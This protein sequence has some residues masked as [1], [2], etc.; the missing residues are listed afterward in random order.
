M[1][2]AFRAGKYLFKLTLSILPGNSEKYVFLMFSAR[3]KR[4]N[5]IKWVKNKDTKIT[6][7]I[8]H[9]LM[10]K[11]ENC[12][13]YMFYFH[14]LKANLLIISKLVNYFVIH[15]NWLLHDD[16][17]SLQYLNE[18]LNAEPTSCVVSG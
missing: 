4:A 5:G 14:P 11:W 10:R 1:T 3:V 13:T 17:I 9:V 15:I 2:K 6:C 8:R 12:K 16:N 7:Y 18:S